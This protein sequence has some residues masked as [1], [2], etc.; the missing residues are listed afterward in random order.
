MFD[1]QNF[2]PSDEEMDFM[3]I[4]PLTEEEMSGDEIAN[5]PVDLD[6][7]ALRNMVL[8]PNIVMPITVSRDKSLRAL[9]DAEKKGKL[10]GVV[11]QID[12]KNENPNSEIDSKI[13]DFIKDIETV[14]TCY[15]Y[16]YKI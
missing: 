3:P 13:M 11:A 2:A 5:L 10:I 1:R 8:Y 12:N 15:F 4:V 14:G 6:V 9:A 16:I 7:I